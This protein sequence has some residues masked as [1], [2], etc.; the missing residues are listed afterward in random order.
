MLFSVIVGI[1]AFIGFAGVACF[2]IFDPYTGVNKN[3]AIVVGAVV[4]VVALAFI[5]TSF[6]MGFAGVVWASFGVVSLTIGV[7]SLFDAV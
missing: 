1:L 6:G 3:A 2:V 4:G 7:M 5:L